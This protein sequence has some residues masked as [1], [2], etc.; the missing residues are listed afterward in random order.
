MPSHLQQFAH[1]LIARHG[2][3]TAGMVWAAYVN[4]LGN[5]V[6]GM[7]AEDQIASIEAE[8]R[9]DDR[10]DC[11]DAPEGYHG[12]ATFAHARNHQD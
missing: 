2:P 10:L 11:I 5:V 9:L 12:G 3:R 7:S 6:K 8:L 1:H 4:Q